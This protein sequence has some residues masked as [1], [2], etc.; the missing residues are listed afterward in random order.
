MDCVRSPVSPQAAW[1]PIANPNHDSGEDVDVDSDSD[2]VVI[3][4]SLVDPG[5]F[6][7]IFDRHA[8][9]LHRYLV[10]R[11]GPVD[12]DSLLGDVFLISFEKRSTF[13]TSRASARPWLYGIATN[14]IGR[15]RRSEERRLR[16]VGRL[17]GRRLPD[18]DLAD[19][20]TGAVDAANLWNQLAARI[21]ELPDAERDTLMLHAWEALSY[22]E[23]ADVLEI[24]IGTVRS[25]LNRARRRIRE[26][27][28]A[29]GEQRGD[30]NPGR[31]GS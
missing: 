22:E 24:P 18:T 21:V 7:V 14:L 16:A 9:V 12:A 5:R 28:P 30:H 26:L 27:D 2:A 17:A 3:A 31:I 29:S 6:G 11:V 10:R 8:T 19:Q 13:D 25:R 20:V 1:P 4:G 23:I 15:H